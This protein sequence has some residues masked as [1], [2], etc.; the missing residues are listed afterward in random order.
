MDEPPLT[1]AAESAG[2]SE[3]GLSNGQRVHVV[4]NR[5]RIG[6]VR[7]IGPVKGH[8]GEWVGVEWDDGEGKHDGQVDGVRY[9]TANNE[10][11]AS[12]V[13]LKNLSRGI[14]LLEALYHRYRGESTKEEEDEMY[15]FSSSKRRV[16]IQL[17]GKSKVEEKLKNFE[18]LNGASMPY[19]GV[20]SVNPSQEI[21]NVVSNLKELDLR[22]N[23][24]SRWQDINSICE[25]LPSLEILNLTNNLMEIDVPE[26][27]SLTNI[28]V[29]VLNNCG[30]TWKQVE[31]LGLYL[32]AVEELHLMGNKI[33]LLLPSEPDITNVTGFKSLR[34]L[35]LE[36]NCISSWQEV[37]K[38]SK[39]RSLEQ[40]HLNKNKLSQIFYPTCRS[41]SG[42]QD[43]CYAPFEKLEC[44]LLGSNEINDLAS[45]DY[46]N[47][48]PN[49]VSKEG[50]EK[51]FF[52][53]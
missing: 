4:G 36:N 27:P 6:T 51:L 35:N 32:H 50:K 53:Y 17:V 30:I 15:V 7:Y 49:L 14:S 41:L 48:F 26:L 34:L 16:S 37:L 12:F 52:S 22:G 40:L 2:K 13:R 38:L 10:Q 8:A 39:L 3:L 1:A 18:D 29:L 9:F 42:L 23:L 33:T 45:V 11:S 5:R 44:L 43:G 25:A 19:F 47:S 28:R 24:L 46:L 21:S 31:M 20:G